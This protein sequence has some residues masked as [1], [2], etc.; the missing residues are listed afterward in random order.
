MFQYTTSSL[1]ATLP[2]RAVLLRGDSSFGLLLYLP[3]P[4]CP[5]DLFVKTTNYFLIKC[6]FAYKHREYETCGE[7][8]HQTNR[9]HRHALNHRGLTCSIDAKCRGRRPLWSLDLSLSQFESDHDTRGIRFEGKA[10][11]GICLIHNV[12]REF[13]RRQFFHGSAR[14]C[15]VS[16]AFWLHARVGY[17][18]RSSANDGKAK[19]AIREIDALASGVMCRWHGRVMMKSRDLV[20]RANEKLWHRQG[21]CAVD[22]MTEGRTKLLTQL[23]QVKEVHCNW[24]YLFCFD[25]KAKNFITSLPPTSIRPHAGNTDKRAGRNIEDKRVSTY[26]S[27]NLNPGVKGFPLETGSLA[28][29][30]TNIPYFLGQVGSASLTLPPGFVTVARCLSS[31][32]SSPFSVLS[33]NPQDIQGTSSTKFKASPRCGLPKIL[34]L[35]PPLPSRH[36][37][38]P[39]HSLNNHTSTRWADTR[40]LLPARPPAPLEASTVVLQDLAQRP[41]PSGIAVTVALGPLTFKSMNIAPTANINGAHLARSL[42]SNIT[43]ADED[44]MLNSA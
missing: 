25:Y 27:V 20:E 24:F 4:E 11:A 31:S 12:R 35:S 17:C 5:V 34:I 3:R 10:L 32:S 23:S 9:H 16:T 37:L 6:P 39:S 18:R 14:A 1:V 22:W 44:L 13:H 28:L 19:R 29:E 21:L 15:P 36:W 26:S 33:V 42:P 8:Q 7:V 43:P 38:P 30:V 40:L 41:K 2:N